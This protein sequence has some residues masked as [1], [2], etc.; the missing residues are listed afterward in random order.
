M[1]QIY[2]TKGKRAQ[3]P[4]E[5]EGFGVSVYTIEEIGYLICQKTEL[6]AN[7]FVSE[8]LLNFIQ[9]ELGISCNALIRQTM[10]GITLT[11]FCLELLK[12]LTFPVEASKLN[13]IK[14]TLDYNAT[15]TEFD[16]SKAFADFLLERKQYVK[17]FS[18]YY[19]LGSIAENN[20][21][22]AYILAGMGK[23][24]FALFDYQSAE[25]YFKE[26]LDL[27]ADDMTL[28][29]YLLCKRF[30]LS[31]QEY[32]NYAATHAQYYSAILEVEAIYGKAQ[33]K[34]DEQVDAAL[35]KPQIGDVL[36]ELAGMME[37]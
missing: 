10:Q 26:S 22:R 27:E 7:D 23:A 9:N 35:L 32:T 16:K 25:A 12:L 6:I 1:S 3:T 15:L 8:K 24:C 37:E 20:H 33:S 4:L 21:H 29:Y 13:K 2:L 17:A 31:K 14:E 34:A 30:L 5:L 28:K 19:S 18:A 36:A 11:D